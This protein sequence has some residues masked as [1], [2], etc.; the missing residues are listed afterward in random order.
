MM[1]FPK[2]KTPVKVSYDKA[3]L[4]KTTA[5]NDECLS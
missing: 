5:E 1:I 3:K 4:N 2:K